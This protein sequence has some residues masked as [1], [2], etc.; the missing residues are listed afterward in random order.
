[1]TVSGPVSVAVTGASG[2]IG[3]HLTAALL[4]RGDRVSRVRRPFEVAA[5]REAFQQVDVV[6]HLAGVLS[7]VRERAFYLAN[8]DATRVVAEAARAAD[9]R[10]IHVSSLAAAGP[11]PVTSPRSEDDPPLPITPYGR[12]KLEGELVVTRTPGLRWTVL[13]PGVVYGP[14]D[15]AMRPL[16]RLATLGILPVVGRSSS[17][18]M[19]IHVD[20]LV[21]ALTA[22]IDRDPAGKTFFVAHPRPATARELLEAIRIAVGGRSAIVPLPLALTRLAAAVGDVAG[23]VSGRPAFINRW[24]YAELAADGFVC[25]VERMRAGLGLE[26]RIELRDGIAMTVRRA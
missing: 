1:M 7:A 14:G 8:V 17:A 9:A 11:A 5:L 22:A 23:W 19:F 13:R 18:Y 12:S 2:F 20:D 15:R 3:Q 24:R 4:A 25:R 21:R 16:F 26:P 10:L 6:V